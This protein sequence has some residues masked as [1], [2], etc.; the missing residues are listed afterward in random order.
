MLNK[1][2]R[3]FLEN[4]LITFLLLAAFIIG[5]I[6]T[7]PFNWETSLIERNPVPVDAIPDIGENQ[8]IVFTEW[9]GQSPKDIEDQITY[10]LTTALL[11]IPGV[12]TIRSNSIFGLSSIYIIFNDDVDF[13]W[14]RTRIL[15][16]LNS[17][18]PGTVPNE[19]KPALG[20]DATA[21]GQ[22]Y[23]YTLEGRDPKTGKPTGG[24][25]PQELRT[26]QDFYVRYYLTAAS[27]VS[28]VASIGGFIK[29]YQIDIDPDAMK[30]NNVN[31]TQIMNAVKNSNLDIGARTLEFN[32]VEYLVRGLGYIKNLSDLE[33]SVV[34]V[35]DNV[36]IRLKD[37]AKV[38]FGPSTRRGGLDKS[39]VEAVGGVVVARYGANPQ[40]VI[41]N[42]K[43]KI[44]EVAPGLP[45]KTL[46]DGTVS[47][48][49]IVPFY[50]RS[51]LIQETLGT[52]E[53]ALSHEILI[54]IL[55]VLVLVFN[56]RASVLISSL[57]PI[58]VLMTFILMKY[59]NV[60]AN[61]VALSGIAIAI[62]VMVDV[63]IVFTENIVRHLEMPENEGIK[64]KKLLEVI[65]EAA[66]EVASA[67]ITA[68][69]TTVISF[70]PVFAMQA[71][72]GKLFRPLA[73]TKTF[74]LISSL[75]IG[76][77][78]IPAF[79]HVLFS[80]R[81]DKKRTSRVFGSIL[82]GFGIVF[83]FY[84]G[85]LVALALI[86]FGLNNILTQVSERSL[87]KGKIKLPYTK[88][89][90]NYINIAIS[91]M[92]LVYFL[93][94]EWMPLG[95]SNS[96]FVNFIFVVIVI[97]VVLGLLMTIVHFYKPILLW[98]LDNKWKFLS[99][100]IIIVF[101]G[102]T[103]W[104]GFAKVFSFMPDFTK[105]N[106]AWNK[107][108]KSFPGLGNEFMPAL[109]EGSFLL[110]PTTMPHSGIT[111]NMEVIATINKHM[112]SIPEIATS[113]GK[114]GRVNS[115]LDPAPTSMYENTINYIPE[116][117]LDA[118][119]RKI[120]F[121]VN[122]DDAFIL[123][124]DST[125][126]YGEDEFRKIT[127]DQLI[128][129]EDGE[130]FRQW[131][132]KIKKPD[133]IWKEIVKHSKFP[134]LTSAPKLQ[135]IQ[136]R[137]I[138]L[139]TGMRAPMGIKVYGPTL[140][141]I[142]KVG[143]ELE[144]ILKEV[145]SVAPQTVFADRVVGKPYLEIKLNRQ[146]MSRYGLTIK[147]MQTQL[148]V[149]IGGKQLTT[150]VEGRERFP[151]RVRYAREFRDNPD[152]IKKIL[153]PTPAG[154]QVELGELSSIEYVRGPQV[155]KSEDTF[156]TGYVIF[157]MKDGYAETNVVEEAQAL[158]KQKL[159]SGE[160]KLPD[161]VTYKFTGNYEN[162]IRASKRLMIVV[163][164]SLIVILLI[165]YF[166]FKSIT[167]AL[168]VFTGIF[169]AFSG[170]FIMLWLYGQGW[171][172]NFNFAGVS[173]RDL[174]QLHTINLSV[175]VWVG[176]IALFGIATDDGVIMGTYLTQVFEKEKP[177]T[178]EEIRTSVLHAG[179]KRVRPAMMTAATAIIALIPVLTATG[180]GADVVIPMAIPSFGGML[181]AVMTMFVVPVLYSMWKE[182]NLKKE[183]KQL[184]SG[185]H[186]NL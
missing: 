10:P 31:I 86:G 103:I 124:D 170:G 135:P 25:D 155:I 186:E 117:I 179:S 82:I 78:F 98:C 34:T 96:T 99:L 73:F 133:D 8:Q 68:L 14:S 111:E 17:L 92:V 93:T 51:G 114:W 157:D 65:Y 19:V 127:I 152:D 21:L 52:L 54:S 183:L 63:G 178:V 166:Q 174:F 165:L 44:A 7:A 123:K 33:E 164:I 27:G 89:I 158:I 169:V 37:V 97:G 102:V 79:A 168:M 176:F 9:V 172:L 83:L 20:P 85:S 119:G 12:K 84:Y 30:A 45:S 62:G 2:I 77:M 39:G 159:D 57:L 29:E 141:I 6:V 41:Q 18:P 69:A 61:I 147:D 40:E 1:I 138:M 131:R 144:N 136:T 72:E 49:T 80:I 53:S 120:R 59:F 74:A 177:K 4:K 153:I 151:V 90:A 35:R 43:D 42:L 185:T 116:Y 128:L 11:G 15:E 145:P 162:Q 163:P 87:F 115:A 104:L 76:I 106:V 126:K 5:G 132:E 88:K 175:A 182:K 13:Y 112:N 22:V 161:G 16:K 26:I 184:K 48:I 130:Y 67:I 105:N 118:D 149:A 122:N 32:K 24:W 129:D 38:Q 60:D 108:E 66:V 156:L 55:V 167:P 58:G 47:K 94:I 142:E 100:P 171:F 75:F 101:F 173:M 137:L 36:P 160:F 50:D 109:N 125:Y 56:L 23:W 64:G 121:K 139:A 181:I 81:I 150:T 110:M 107:M 46:A 146:A 91:I 95:A 113:V 143:Y 70:L 134:G 28:E 3:Y 148:A 71:S 140:E 180:K 154:P